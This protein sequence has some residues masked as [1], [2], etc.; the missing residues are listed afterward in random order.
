MAN[1][2]DERPEPLSKP[3]PVTGF[4]VSLSLYGPAG[5]ARRARGLARRMP[6]ARQ[7][8]H[9]KAAVPIRICDIFCRDR[10]STRLNSSHS[11]ATRMHSSALKKKIDRIA[12]QD[13]AN[14]CHSDT[15]AQIGP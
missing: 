4:P 2:R 6:R 3:L 9:A 13:N 5:V 11:C 1:L 10:K 15:H 14:T 8:G 12:T 7:V